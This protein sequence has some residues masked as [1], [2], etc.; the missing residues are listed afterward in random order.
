MLAWFSILAMPIAVVV[1]GVLFLVVVVSRPPTVG[2][3]SPTVGGAFPSTLQV[4]LHH[5]PGP[6]DPRLAH[7]LEQARARIVELEQQLSQARELANYWE[8]GGAIRA[9]LIRAELRKTR[10]GQHPTL[11]ALLEDELAVLELR[12]EEQRA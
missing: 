7:K 10:D 6:A 11:R 3:P 8:N 9:D 2:T 5:A 12:S 4:E 1:V